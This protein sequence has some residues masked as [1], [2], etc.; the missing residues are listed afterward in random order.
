MVKNYNSEV[1]LSVLLIGY[2]CIQNQF[3]RR[4]IE[5]KGKFEF[6]RKAPQHFCEHRTPS[7]NKQNIC[8]VSF[9]VLNNATED[10]LDFFSHKNSNLV[11]YDVP[12]GNAD[13]EL[14]KYRS[15]KGILY[16]DAP[17]EHLFRC[18][19]AV[20][21]HDMWLPRKL[22]V[23]MLKESRPYVLNYKEL[24][25]NLTKREQQTLERLVQGQSNLE[26]AEALFVA[27]STVK[28]HVYKLYKKLNV[29]SR[30]E[31]IS[32]MSHQLFEHSK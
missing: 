23:R 20:S 11:V 21:T 19:D 22:M 10:I 29:K 1:I 6:T 8:L 13:I 24:S 28:T 16:Q 18:L 5:K 32:K 2:N 27:E 3:I 31:A 9:N 25:T 15:L 4:E 7:S 17:I 14:C 30:K 26:I 12:D